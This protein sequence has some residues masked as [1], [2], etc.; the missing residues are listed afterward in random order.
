VRSAERGLKWAKAQS[1]CSDA[2]A[3]IEFDAAT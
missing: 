3:K 1:G 2:R